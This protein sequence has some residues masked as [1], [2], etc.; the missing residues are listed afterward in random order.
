MMTTIA[1]TY[2]ITETRVLETTKTLITTTTRTETE[3]VESTTTVTKPIEVR[4]TDWS[5]I[6]S[7]LVL[8]AI[9]AFA[10]GYVVKGLKLK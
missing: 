1:R 10:T 3:T 9:V 4:E 8:V 5:A 2:T 6:A 7:V